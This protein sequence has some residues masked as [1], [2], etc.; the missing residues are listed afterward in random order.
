MGF[1]NYLQ[2]IGC[3]DLS[4]CGSAVYLNTGKIKMDTMLW[5]RNYLKN[6]TQTPAYLFLKADWLDSGNS[7]DKQQWPLPKCSKQ[8]ID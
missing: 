7:P 6:M 2:N 4:T 5:R 1:T 3:F 8:L